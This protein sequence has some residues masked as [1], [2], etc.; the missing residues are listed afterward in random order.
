MRRTFTLAA[1]LT[2]SVAG[3]T[4][5][6]GGTTTPTQQPESTAQVAETPVEVATTPEPAT[7]EPAME[8]LP[9]AEGMIPGMTELPIP[10]G[11]TIL[12]QSEDPG[13][14]VID[15]MTPDIPG[16]S[17]FYEEVLPGLGYE[18]VDGAKIT[19]G[20]NIVRR[21][22]AFTNDDNTIVGGLVES[23]L[24]Y[25]TMTIADHWYFDE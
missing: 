13:N 16:V 2:L 22:V 18:L 3:L 10:A 21:D 19:A 5:C 8:M 14:V 4:A 24:G 12:N 11:A 7:A 9:I 17:D 23:S 15:I 6:S 20:Q 1:A 25:A